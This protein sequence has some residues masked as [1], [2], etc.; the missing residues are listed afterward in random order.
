MYTLRQISTVDDGDELSV[1]G[2]NTNITASRI[3]TYTAC[4]RKMSTKVLGH[5]TEVSHV[6][7][8]FIAMQ[9][10]QRVFRYI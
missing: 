6:Y 1:L 2:L 8:L 3:H 4:G 10:C 9:N 5:W 7:Y